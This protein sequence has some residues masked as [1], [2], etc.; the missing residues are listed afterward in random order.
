MSRQRRSREEI[1]ETFKVCA[2]Q[3]GRTPGKGELEKRTG[4]KESE[5]KYYWA[6]YT[7]LAQEAG[8]EANLIQ[9]RLEDEVV[10]SDYA[11][12]CELLQKIPSAAELRLVQREHQTKTHTVYTRFSGGI[13]EFHAR[14]RSWLEASPADD[15]QS[16]LRF[17]GWRILPMT[18]NGGDTPSGTSIQ[19]H[20]G[21][22]PFLP[23]SLQYFHLLAQGERPPYDVIDMS[24]DMLFERRTADAFRCLGFEMRQLGQ[25]T[26]RKADSLAVAPR[27]HFA[28]II[29]AKVRSAGYVL[30]TEDRKFLEYADKHGRELQQQGLQRVYFIVVGPSF[31]AN[32]WQQLTKYLSDSPI[33]SITLITASALMRIVE[34]SIRDR[35]RFS[36]IE[37]EKEL[38]AK[39]V[40]SE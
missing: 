33:R 27:E 12:A 17:D 20:P 15:L 16:I 21:L 35:S 28:L 8:L 37:L 40:I 25:G 34:E 19:P 39:R 3:L 24:F 1:L 22:R 7:R 4:I 32:D 23:A 14:F 31:R 13:E 11:R 30:G 6:K 18:G 2:V 38:F 36:L 5:V 26:G 10:F 9:E 29:D